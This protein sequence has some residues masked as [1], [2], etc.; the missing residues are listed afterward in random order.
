[1]KHKHLYLAEA[2]RANSEALRKFTRIDIGPIMAAHIESAYRKKKKRRKKCRKK[3][4]KKGGSDN[5]DSSNSS[6]A[7]VIAV[8]IAVAIIAA[9]MIV[10]IPAPPTCHLSTFP[11]IKQTNKLN[12]Y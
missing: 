8:A 11:T 1:M 5:D 9:I 12:D 3:R 7:V 6:R 10:T 4:R 2:L